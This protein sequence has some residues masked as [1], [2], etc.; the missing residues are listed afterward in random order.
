MNRLSESVKSFFSSAET[1]SSPSD[2]AKLTLAFTTSLLAA[3]G[4]TPADETQQNQPSVSVH[5]DQSEQQPTSEQPVRPVRP[6]QEGS[7]DNENQEAFFPPAEFE[8]MPVAPDTSR[9]FIPGSEDP[10]QNQR[11]EAAYLCVTLHTDAS[12]PLITETHLFCIPD[13][14]SDRQLLIA[15]Q[16]T[17]RAQDLEGSGEPIAICE[18]GSIDESDIVNYDIPLDFSWRAVYLM[19]QRVEEEGMNIGAHQEI[20]EDLEGVFEGLGILSIRQETENTDAIPQTITRRIFLAEELDFCDYSAFYSGS[21]NLE[22]SSQVALGQTEYRIE[23]CET[24]SEQT[25][26]V[27]QVGNGV[28]VSC[29]TVPDVVSVEELEAMCAT[30][31]SISDLQ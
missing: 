28:A 26:I 23:R 21:E 15:D 31:I 1:N 30:A 16:F 9:F 6:V 4:T 25:V 19:N 24:S 10:I 20:L 22:D 17:I 2:L 29:R 11:D 18:I 7:A 27:A 5:D 13:S 12:E 3:C 8:D 14:L